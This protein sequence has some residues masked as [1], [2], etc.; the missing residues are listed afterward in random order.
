M[1]A[2]TFP[3]A[4]AVPASLT[5]AAGHASQATNSA[6]AKKAQLAQAYGKLPLSFEANQ[7][8]ADKNIRFLSSGGGYSLSLTDSSAVLTLTK[9]GAS[10]ARTGPAIGNGPRPAFMEGAGKTD[11]IRMDLAGANRAIR[12]TGMDPLP[13]TA[14]YFIGNDPAKWLS[15]VPTY[16]KVEYSSVYPG[17]DLVYYGSQRQLE[18]DFV[19]APGADPGPIRLQFAGAKALEL[20]ADGD[21]TISAANGEIAFHKPVIYQVKDGLRRPVDGQ[22]AL[23]TKNTIGFTLGSYDH[24]MPMVIDP[25]LAYSTYLGGSLSDGAN[26]IAVDSSGNAYV[27][28]TTFSTNFPVTTGA[29]QSANN[30][31]ANFQC[32]FVSKLNPTGTALVYS[33]YLGGSGNPGDHAIYGDVGIG[34]AVDSSGDAY[35]TGD[36]DSTNFPVTAGAFQT[37]NNCTKLY[38]QNAFVTKLNPA[39]TALVY[40]T[41]LG[42]SSQDYGTGIVV[43]GSGNAYVVGTAHSMNFPITAGAYQVT[44]LA[45]YTDGWNDA[46]VTKLNPTGTALVYSTYLGGSLYG[47]QGTGI[48]VDSSGNAYVTG[49]AASTDFP[50]TAG[51]FQTVNNAAAGAGPQTVAYNVFVTKLNPTGTGLVYSTFL[52][53]SIDDYGAGIAVDSSGDAYVTGQSWSSDYPVTGNAFQP[54]NNAYANDAFNAFVTKVN[55]SGTGLVYSTFLGGTGLPSQSDNSSGAG[56][57]GDAIAVDSSGDAYVTGSAISSN[58][59]TTSDAFQTVNNAAGHLTPIGINAFVTELNPGGSTLLYS[60]YLGGSI[61]DYGLGIALDKLGGIYIAGQASSTNFPVTGG[62]Y[63]PAFAGGDSDAFIAKIAL[64]GSGSGLTSSLFWTDMNT[65][66]RV[67]WLMSDGAYSSSVPLGTVATNWELDGTGDF[68][69]NGQTDILWTNTTTGERIIWLMN[70]AAYSST[71]SLGVIPSNWI[72]SGV[73]AFGGGSQPDIL[74]TDTAT[75]ERLIWLMNGTAY[76]SSVSLGVIPTYWSISGVGTFGGGSQADI[77]WTNTA[78]GERLIWIMNGTS[79]SSSVSLGIVPAELRIS[80]VGNLNGNGSA[81]L[82]MTNAETNQRTVWIMNGTSYVSTVSLGTVTDNWVLGQSGLQPVELAKLDFNGDGQPDI[83]FENTT[84]GDHYVWLM[85]GTNFSSSVFI[86]NV[87]T[88]WQVVGTGDFTG[89]GNADLLWQ[90]SSTGEILIWLMNGTTYVSSVEV[91]VA[92]AGWS[93]AAV[94]DFNG[95]GNPDILWS[96]A[97]TGERLIWLMNGTSFSSSVSLGIVGTQWRIADTGD[98]LGDG[99]PD[100][101]FENTSTGD[102]YVWLMDGTAFS[103]SVFLGNVGTQWRIA[104]TEEFAG[105]GQPDIVFENTSTGDRVIW[106]MNGT[107]FESSVDLGNVATQWQIRN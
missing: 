24:S 105:V 91:G 53:G 59:P 85:N 82:V 98:F 66:N 104:A 50:I 55:P 72:I 4:V 80:A 93:V 3:T 94:A 74:W 68:T 7:G 78:T 9:P 20:T 33:T 21:L 47:A 83:L 101:V 79:F 8:Q 30:E 36:A 19:V 29:F 16:A 86:G 54:T 57:T 65:G 70:G 87:S 75:G 1:A 71:V 27:V 6:A 51:A 22:F 58:F 56:D 97:T 43:D 95:D 44:F 88:Q 35:V 102:R 64:S 89:D 14:N 90:N 45:D 63:Q 52:G 73:G 67:V 5:S 18:Y 23:L 42:G 31:P 17:I 28:G 81:D 13:G 11:I 39:G 46:F 107:A 84:T 62:A 77:V 103:S 37:V 99:Q 100:I 60:T 40:S 48:A 25:M 2:G 10:N 32:V 76:S 61:Q 38:V 106:R 49:S 34:I 41:Y 26:G 12:V 69:A 96:N 15:G 92:P